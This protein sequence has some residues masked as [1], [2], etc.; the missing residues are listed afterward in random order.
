MGGRCG[1]EGR[2]AGAGGLVSD[3][4]GRR[5]PGVEGET[6]IRGRA[7]D[8]AA[9][10]EARVGGREMGPEAGGAMGAAGHRTAAR[11]YSVGVMCAATLGIY[12]GLIAKNRAAR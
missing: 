10:A 9:W 8:A 5:E 7:G 1:A 3:A 4:G 12:A 2:A 11:H 6:G